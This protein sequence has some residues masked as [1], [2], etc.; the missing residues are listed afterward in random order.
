M[1]GTVVGQQ[2]LSKNMV[3]FQNRFLSEVDAD[4]ARVA[5]ILEAAVKGN[6]SESDH[7]LR[8]LAK[9]GHPYGMGA[10]AHKP[11]H[12]PNYI[13]HTQSG[14]ML[15]GLRSGSTPASTSGLRLAAEAFAG[16]LQS[17]AHAQNVFYGTSKMI[18]RDFLTSAR[19]KVKDECLD[20]LRRSL[21]STVINFDGEKTKL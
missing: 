16:I 12:T 4:M 13:V 5:K 3:V 6:I 2:L 15:G 7:S 18:P 17:I 1:Q 21:R 9:L 11:L 19:D 10:R 8:D 20:V 14:Q